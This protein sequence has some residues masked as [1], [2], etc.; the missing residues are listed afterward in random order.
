MCYMTSPHSY[1]NWL[2]A[3]SATKVRPLGEP[4]VAGGSPLAVKGS[5]ETFLKTY[6]Q[7]IDEPQLKQR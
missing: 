1:W 2:S 6:E 4:A 7:P 5:Y 3:D